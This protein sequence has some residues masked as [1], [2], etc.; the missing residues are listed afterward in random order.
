MLNLISSH[1]LDPNICCYLTVWKHWRHT[2]GSIERESPPGFKNLRREF[3]PSDSY[4]GGPT[5]KAT[6]RL[7]RYPIGFLFRHKLLPW[8]TESLTVANSN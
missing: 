2:Q 1:V 8:R 7:F 3:L 5:G 6:L 4:H